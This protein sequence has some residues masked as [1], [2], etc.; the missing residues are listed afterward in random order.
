MAETPEG[1]R[2]NTYSRHFWRR[3]NTR[4]QRNRNKWTGSFVPAFN[5]DKL[6]LYQRDGS[7]GYH[8]LNIYKAPHPSTN[9]KNRPFDI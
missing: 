2:L 3:L 6:F 8:L 4:E 9:Q 1:R 5:D 7:F